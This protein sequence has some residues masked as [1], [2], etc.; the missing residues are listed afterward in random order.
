MVV[1]SS[2]PS[3]LDGRRERSY[4]QAILTLETLQVFVFDFRETAGTRQL[5]KTLR[6]GFLFFRFG[7]HSWN[8]VEEVDGNVVEGHGRKASE[9][10]ATSQHILAQYGVAWRFPTNFP[11]F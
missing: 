7:H 6:T 8:P 1:T 4:P 2:V 3:I 5:H 10:V 11:T 9:P